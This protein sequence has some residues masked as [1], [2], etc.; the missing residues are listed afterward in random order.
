MNAHA[1]TVQRRFGAEAGNWSG[2]YGQNPSDSIYVHNLHRRKEQA[3]HL[4]KGIRGRI[5]EIGCGAGNVILSLPAEDGTQTFG[6][7]FSPFMLRQ[8]TENASSKQR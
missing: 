1:R 7:D 4:L 8:A 3:L 2:L 5:L 6:S